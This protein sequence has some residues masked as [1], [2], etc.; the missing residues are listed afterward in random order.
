MKLAIIMPAYNE[1]KRIGKT[2][3]AYSS[4]FETLRK[5]KKLDYTILVMINNTKD[6]TEEIV[7][8]FQKK[9]KQISYINLKQGGKG[10]AVREGFREAL[11]DK[12]HTLIG[13]VDA[14]MSTRPEE[15]ARLASKIGDYD[16]IIASRYLKG[17][18]VKPKPTLKRMLA[19]RLYNL[20]IRFLFFFPFK[21]TQCGAKIFKRRAV[22]KILPRLI[23]AKWAFDVDWL[24]NLKRFGFKTREEPT[25]WSDREYSKI[26]FLRA[27]PFMALSVLRLR[28]IN[29]P[30]NFVMRFYDKLPYWVKIHNKLN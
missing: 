21:D 25:R 5:S 15:Y 22:E 14:D 8:R 27:G 26:N 23:H 12:K 28:L 13:F 11:K 30:F 6:R 18:I 2:L 29:S 9:N 1:E 7:K 16:A 10:N 20:F 4:Y 24:Y 3:E 17:A 19:A